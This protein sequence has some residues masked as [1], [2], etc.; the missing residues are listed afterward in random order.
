MRVAVGQDTSSLKPNAQ[1]WVYLP[2][3]FEPITISFSDTA[4]NTNLFP[5]IDL[6]PHFSAAPAAHGVEFPATVSAW[7]RSVTAGLLVTILCLL[8]LAI[9]IRIRIQHPALITHASF[10]IL[11]AAVLLAL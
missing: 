2:S 7:G 10:V 4:G 8:M 5:S 9:F 6:V 11:L 1:G 3:I